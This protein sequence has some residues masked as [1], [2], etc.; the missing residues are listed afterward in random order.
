MGSVVRETALLSDIMTARRVYD[1]VEIQ[2]EEKRDSE[3][4]RIRT[5]LEAVSQRKEVYDQ[6]RYL[7][8]EGN[9]I[10]RINF[11]D[12]HAQVVPPEQL[13]NKR[14]RYYFSEA[15]QLG[16]RKIYVSPLD[17][18]IEH[19]QIEVPLKPM[20]RLASPVYDDEGQREG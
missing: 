19:G 9:E 6:L 20:I 4:S 5:I 3:L 1:M 8:M 12:D 18:N 14:H 10:V 17:L 13:Q 16:C 7:D 2:P 11:K 15:V